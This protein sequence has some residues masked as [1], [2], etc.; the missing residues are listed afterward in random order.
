MGGVD[1]EVRTVAPDIPAVLMNVL[2][3][4]DKWVSLRQRC[5]QLPPVDCHVANNLCDKGCRT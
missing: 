4:I 2:R 1:Y 5:Y 3:S